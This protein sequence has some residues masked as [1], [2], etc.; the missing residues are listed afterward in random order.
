MKPIN[1]QI[2]LVGLAMSLGILAACSNGAD[3]VMQ[4]GQGAVQFVMSASAVAPATLAATSP[5]ISSSDHPLQA[6]NV[7]FA[8]ILA[9]NLDGELINVT[10]DLPVTV[11]LI[12]LGTD[13]SFTLPAGF[14]PPGTYDQIVIVMTQVALTLENGTIVTIEP[15]G[16]GWTAVLAVADPFTVA[17]GQTTTVDINFRA[18]GLFRWLDGVWE[19]HPD[20]D[21]PGDDGGHHDTNHDT[22]NGH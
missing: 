6:A 12:G 15:P 22:N 17:E 20:F 8:S 9:R 7:T 14:L 16:G 4:G 21:C 19:F 3:S 1:N 11:D 10:I 5:E 2:A 18:G 13:G